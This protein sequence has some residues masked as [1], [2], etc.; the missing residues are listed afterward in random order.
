MDPMGAAKAETLKSMAQIKKLS[1]RET[2]G[3]YFEVEV[4][5]TEDEIRYRVQNR[6]FWEKRNQK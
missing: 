3:Q 1:F 2:F 6:M 4:I 5:A